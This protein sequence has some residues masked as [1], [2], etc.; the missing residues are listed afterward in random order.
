[1][2]NGYEMMTGDGVWANDMLERRAVLSTAN[3]AM[4]ALEG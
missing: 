3:Q 2:T 1:M 4:D